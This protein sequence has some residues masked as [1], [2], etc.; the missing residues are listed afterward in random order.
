MREGNLNL[1][2]V[3]DKFEPAQWQVQYQSLPDVKSRERYLKR[4]FGREIK[5][6]LILHCSAFGYIP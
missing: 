4:G 6:K 1:Q 5:D 2:A 3:M